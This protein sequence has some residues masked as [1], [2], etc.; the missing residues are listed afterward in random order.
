M[1][2]PRLVLC[3][4]P[5][6]FMACGSEAD[7]SRNVLLVCVD[8]LRPDLGCMDLPSAVTPSM[9]ALA[10]EGRLFRHHYVSVPTCG[11]SRFA[12]LSGRRPREPRSFGNSAFELLQDGQGP[13]TFAQLFRESGYRTICIGKVSHQPDG[14]IEGEPQMPSAWNEVGA[15]RGKW[16]NSWDAFFAYADGS[17]RTRGESPPFE[18]AEVGDDGYPDGLIAKAAA[19][20]LGKLAREDKPFLLAVGFYKP[21]LPWAS[22]RRYWD[23]H[24]ADSISLPAQ[25]RPPVGVERSIS[26]HGSGELLH[27]YGGYAGDPRV[28]EDYA[29]HLRRAYRAAVSY[30]D[31]Q[32]GVVLEALEDTG[33]ADSTVVVLW[34]DH[35]W[36]LGDHGVWGKH[37][38]HERS[39][40]SPLIVRVPGMARA[41]EATGAIVESVDLFPTLVELCGLELPAGLPGQSLV[42]LLKDPALASDG[43]A[44]SSWRKS[45][46]LRGL[47]VR[48]D[49]WRL[50]RWTRDGEEVLVE[51]YDH[52]ED[53]EESVNVAAEHPGVVAELSAGAPPSE[54]GQ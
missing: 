26:L 14:R 9:D 44:V 54:T 40:R 19:A 20:R 7:A 51:L 17:G 4:L 46:G 25:P 8:D 24:P 30:V 1:L 10:A 13:V 35:G 38:L 47:S 12:M 41:G 48:S 27:N 36:H 39:L 18:V 22:P 15:P 45:G 3:C 32:V 2:F 34:S 29:R 16:A 37:T 53:P 6:L 23:L 52:G 43:R 31:T 21:H 28:D 42:P 49:R 11:A 5:P 50:T 33:L